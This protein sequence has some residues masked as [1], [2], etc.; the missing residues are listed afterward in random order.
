MRIFV[1]AIVLVAAALFARPAMAGYPCPAGPG[2]GEQQIGVA[3]GSHGIAAV[4]VCVQTGG[5]ASAGDHA[6]IGYAGPG[7]YRCEGCNIFSDEPSRHVGAIDNQSARNLEAQQLVMEARMKQ[8]EMDT[9]AWTVFQGRKDSAPGENCVAMWSRKGTSVSI[10]GPAKAYKGGMLIFWSTEIPRPSDTRTVA[11]TLKQ[12]RYQPQSVN[13]LNFAVPGIEAGA[14]G[15]TVPDIQTALG[16]MLDIE[17]FTVEMD[18]RPVA[19]IEW[20]DGLAARG[21]LQQCIGSQ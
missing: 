18:G 12:S 5:A 2:P 7:G 19:D 21:R 15:L 20:T 11:V 8:Q 16:T 17:H 1:L 3:G 9:G 14:V 6:G 10:V 13:A 4:P